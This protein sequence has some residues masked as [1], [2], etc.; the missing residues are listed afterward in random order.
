MTKVDLEPLLGFTK[1]ARGKNLHRWELY[2]APPMASILMAYFA[3][4]GFD[5]A[6]EIAAGDGS[7]DLMS[8]ESER[9]EAKEEHPE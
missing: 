2:G 9:D 4:Y 8:L 7:V 1:T 5:L 6:K 3:R